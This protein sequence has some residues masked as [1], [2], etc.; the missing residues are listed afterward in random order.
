MIGAKRVKKCLWTCKRSF[1]RHKET[2]I[3]S[4][5]QHD[6]SAQ[7]GRRIEQKGSPSGSEQKH[8]QLR[9]WTNKGISIT[10]VSEK[11]IV[12]LQETKMTKEDANLFDMLFAAC[13]FCVFFGNK[14]GFKNCHGCV[15]QESASQNNLA[16]LWRQKL[17]RCCVAATEK[18]QKATTS[19]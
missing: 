8:L 15:W 19:Q 4:L 17:N 5:R 3:F 11:A 9:T 14:T 7:H 2:F 1:P 13:V 10:G 12:C 16:K 6:N 18:Y